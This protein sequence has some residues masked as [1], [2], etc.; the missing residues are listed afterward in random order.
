MAS[1]NTSTVVQ[2]ILLLWFNLTP[3]F[4]AQWVGGY[5]LPIEITVIFFSALI[6][7]ALVMA[8]SRVRLGV[9]WG[10]AIVASILVVVVLFVSFL[11]TGSL[12]GLIISNK[13]LI[14]YA[15]IATFQVIFLGS[16]ALLNDA[17]RQLKER[18]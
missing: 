17:E 11:L 18:Q 16:M 14:T 10:P 3:V 8:Y 2:I 6:T 15:L 13:N 1:K 4:W 9:K 12:I 7:F 5:N